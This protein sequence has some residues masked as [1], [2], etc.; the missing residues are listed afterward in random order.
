VADVCNAPVS[1]LDQDEGA[2]FGAALQAL[3]A[4]EGGDSDDLEQLLEDHL[5]RNE[6]LC[7]EPK[8]SAV[9]FYDETY[10]AYQAAVRAI[11]P[12]YS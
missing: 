2:S 8:K 11:T 12:L 3:C 4:I 9:N 5:G 10:G 6:A 7:C 1:V